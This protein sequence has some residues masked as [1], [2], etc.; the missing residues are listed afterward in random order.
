MPGNYNN[1][2]WVIDGVLA[3]TCMPYVDAARRARS[4]GRL[5]DYRD[6]LPV[7]HAAGIRAVVCLLNIPGDK[8][9]FESAGFQFLCLPIHDGHP[10][11]IAQAR[12]FIGFVDNCRLRNLPVA[13]FCHAGI[14]RTGTMLCCYLIHTGMTAAD[15]VVHARRSEP[16]AVETMPQRQFLHEFQ[17]NRGA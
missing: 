1:L 3:G 2:W 6:E 15:A 8:P 11:T 7:L 14:G 17:S 9:V 4:G 5:D 16:S 12:E 13:A 10:P